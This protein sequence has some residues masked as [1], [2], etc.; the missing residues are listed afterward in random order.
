MGVIRRV[1][2]EYFSQQERQLEENPHGV[3]VIQRRRALRDYAR[4]QGVELLVGDEQ[5]SDVPDKADNPDEWLSPAAKAAG[6]AVLREG[7][8]Q[9]CLVG[10]AAAYSHLLTH[11]QLYVLAGLAAKRQA[12]TILEHIKEGG[13]TTRTTVLA[14]ASGTPGGGRGRGIPCWTLGAVL[15]F[16][17]R[18]PEEAE[19]LVEALQAAGVADVM[20]SQHVEGL[21]RVHVQVRRFGYQ[22]LVVFCK[23]TAPGLEDALVWAAPGYDGRSPERSTAPEDQVEGG[24]HF[25]RL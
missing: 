6:E 17:P 11:R 19:A 15:V 5:Y 24:G 21:E 13:S 25:V 8:A 18:A 14:R 2:D 12:S 22:E 16:E 7:A 4:A 20:A 9:R 10:A 3:Y 1:S 23:E